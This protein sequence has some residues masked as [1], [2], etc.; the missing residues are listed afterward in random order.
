MS[1]KFIFVTGGVVS[2]LGKGIT[3]A[4]LG[5]LLKTRGLKVAAQKFDPYMNID[6]SVM[7]PLQHGEVFV[8]EDGAV[9]DLDLGHYERFIDENLN[10]YSSLTSGRIYWAVLS[11]AREGKYGG[12]T[13][14]IIPHVTNEIKNSIYANAKATKADV[15]ITEI[16]GTVGDI[17]SLPFIEAIRQVALEKGRQNCLFMHVTLVPFISASNEYKSKP[18]QHSVQQLQSYGISPNIIV[19]RSDKSIEELRGKISQFCNVKKDCVIENLDVEYLYAAPLAL[20]EKG[21]DRVVCRELRLK[22][23][24]P[25]LT[26]WKALVESIENRSGSVKIAIVGEYIKLPD[27]YLSVVEAINHAG[28]GAGVKIEISWI[29]SGS[30]DKSAVPDKKSTPLSDKNAQTR[31]KGVHGIIVPGTI[32]ESCSA[33]ILSAVKYARENDIPYFGLG[34]GMHALVIEFARNVIG[35]KDAD[36]HE[37]NKK[38]T[39]LVI[40]DQVKLNGGKLRVGK[41]PCLVA[42]D[43]KLS[44]IYGEAEEISERHNHSHG[45]NALSKHINSITEAGLKVSGTSPNGEMIEAVELPSHKFFVGA[46]FRPEFKSRP[47]HPQPLFSAFVKAT[48]EATEI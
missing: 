23:K 7:S 40:D 25:D 24:E 31:L 17:E 20:H 34:L 4:S 39:C 36:S 16:G 43:T 9:T 42:K 10:K 28:Y 14:Q 11:K 8:T 32:G 5:R 1:T 21:L 13:V 3:A 37:F 30:N 35:L 22:T 12:Q 38:G 45:L 33:G 47:N 26:K 46:Q 27:A 18:T 19:T 6:P 29:F 2:G 48:I 15:V 41:Y 44:Q